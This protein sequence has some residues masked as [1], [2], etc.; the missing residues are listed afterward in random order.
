M[1]KKKK[2]HPFFKGFDLK[3]IKFDYFVMLFY[4]L[5]KKFIV[6]QAGFDFTLLKNKKK[7]DYLKTAL[8]SKSYHYW[9]E[10]GESFR[11]F[12]A[13]PAIE[14]SLKPISKLVPA[15]KWTLSFP[16]SVVEVPKFKNEYFARTQLAY[17][18]G[19][20][21]AK[22]DIALNVLLQHQ[23]YP[24]QSTV[25]A[26]VSYLQSSI[27]LD[28]KRQ[29]KKENKSIDIR[30]FAGGYLWHDEQ[31]DNQTFNGF[32]NS[33]ND[34]RGSYSIASHG[35]NDET[36]NDLYLG[37]SERSGVM[38]HQLGHNTLIRLPLNPV[39]LLPSAGAGRSLVRRPE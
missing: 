3:K 17:W 8:R 4:S 21:Q 18:V 10:N 15:Q 14:F 2:F 27:D 22:D 12:H 36:F 5:D 32:E 7:I 39:V 20:K 6:G 1:N 24:E 11:Y 38:S 35:Y 28:Y 30:L 37:R 19:K 29:Y 34:I 31:Y 33:S 23:K 13:S 9:S 26:D 25:N 16:F